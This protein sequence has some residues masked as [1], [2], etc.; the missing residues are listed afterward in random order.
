MKNWGSTLSC[1]LIQ[2][3]P[4]VLTIGLPI[5]SLIDPVGKNQVDATAIKN[6]RVAEPA[7]RN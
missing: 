4:V 5:V 3:I 1:F 6:S 7:A 2:S